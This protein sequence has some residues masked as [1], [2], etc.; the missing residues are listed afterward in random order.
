[1][2]A[3]RQLK[4]RERELRKRLAALQRDGSASAKARSG[5]GHAAGASSLPPST[6]G[7]HDDEHSDDEDGLEARLTAESEE[8]S[9]MIEKLEDKEWSQEVEARIEAEKGA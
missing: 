6:L 2:E 5:G 9:A 7:A 1:M 3:T 8:V 4:A